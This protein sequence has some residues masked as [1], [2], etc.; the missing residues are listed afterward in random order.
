MY[1]TL[2]DFKLFVYNNYVYNLTLP[3]QSGFKW[4]V[5]AIHL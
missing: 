2:N 4:S 3:T 1:I 5:I